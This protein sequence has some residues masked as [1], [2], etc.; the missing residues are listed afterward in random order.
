MASSFVRPGNQHVLSPFWYFIVITWR[1]KYAFISLALVNVIVF[2]TVTKSIRRTS[3]Y[4]PYKVAALSWRCLTTFKLKK[5]KTTQM[6]LSCYVTIKTDVKSRLLFCYHITRWSKTSC[7]PE[8]FCV[9]NSSRCGACSCCSSLVGLVKRLNSR[10]SY[11]W[12]TL[13]TDQ[14]H[15]AIILTILTTIVKYV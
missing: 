13:V 8:H 11:T 10:G 14:S 9:V 1:S 2:N 4:S 5:K 3:V 12:S 7:E 6:R 15:I